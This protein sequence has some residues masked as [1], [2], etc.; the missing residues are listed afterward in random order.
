MSERRKGF[1][2]RAK[3]LGRWEGTGSRAK[4][5][6]LDFDWWMIQVQM[7]GHERCGEE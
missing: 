5:E 4:V 7:L 2:A 3:T 1:I 6:D